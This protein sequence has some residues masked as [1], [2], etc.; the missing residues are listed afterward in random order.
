MV[1]LVVSEPTL[2]R[3]GI[4]LLLQARLPRSELQFVD[5]A[6]R[7]VANR[8]LGKPPVLLLVDLSHPDV[9]L[10]Q[11]LEQL[12][13]TY[14]G[15]PLVGLAEDRDQPEIRRALAL[16]ARLC[17]LKSASAD[18]L[19]S[20]LQIAQSNAVCLTA[21]GWNA[22][23]GDD[24][25]VHVEIRTPHLANGNNPTPADLGLT[26]K[27]SR[28]LLLLLQGKSAKGIARELGLCTGTVKTHTTAVLRALNVNTR[29]QAVLAARRM[30][31]Q[32]D[33]CH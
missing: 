1:I 11:G 2:F 16:G 26:P 29:V 30:G 32:V 4:G 3:E 19:M 10:R 28:V 8:R 5:T 24:I 15:I 14:T 22:A 18:D 33:L 27:Q 25:P 17:V 21:P 6:Q 23:L 9:S 7:A 31:L 12:T 20:A 13:A